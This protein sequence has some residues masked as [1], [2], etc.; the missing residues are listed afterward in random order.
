MIPPTIP[1]ILTFGFP[2]VATVDELG[3]KEEEEVVDEGAQVM[4]WVAPGSVR[5]VEEPT[6]TV[7]TMLLVTT[8]TCG[9][10]SVVVVA[11]V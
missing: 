8:V 4:V 6:V 11:V 9:T 2:V 1:A 5:K 3:F 10:L 7:R